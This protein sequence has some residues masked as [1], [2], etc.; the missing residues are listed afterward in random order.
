MASRRSAESVPRVT[1]LVKF[2][3]PILHKLLVMPD[4]IRHPP[5]LGAMFEDEGRSR[6]KAGMTKEGLAP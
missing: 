2:V 3:S 1:K 6:L 5:F 4:L